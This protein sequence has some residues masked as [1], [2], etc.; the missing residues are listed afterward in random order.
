MEA[1]KNPITENNDAALGSETTKQKHARLF[2]RGVKWLAGGLLFSAISFAVTFVMFH[3]DG[4]SFQNIMYVM[5]TLGVA[6]IM[7]GMV[8]I[9]GGF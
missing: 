8:D 9:M 3:S 1:I 7:K 2:K 4:G 5:N 6:C